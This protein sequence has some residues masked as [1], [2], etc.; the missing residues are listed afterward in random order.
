MILVHVGNHVHDSG[1]QHL[2]GCGD[3]ACWTLGDVMNDL[4]SVGYKFILCYIQF[5]LQGQGNIQNG[6]SM[7]ACTNKD[8]RK[9]SDDWIAPITWLNGQHLLDS[10]FNFK[11][12]T[13]LLALTMARMSNK[14]DE[15]D[16]LS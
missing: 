4:G 7:H 5:L 11:P 9:C 8:K 14:N 2:W 10:N 16:T 13:S 3:I 15:F 12:R 6:W 1:F